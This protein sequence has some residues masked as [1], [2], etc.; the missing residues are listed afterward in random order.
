MPTKIIHISDIHVGKSD[1]EE[2]NFDKI[3]K[4]IVN[5][6][7]ESDK[8]VILITGDLVDDGKEKQ[9]VKAR[10]I[11]EPL[12]E[13]KFTL[14]PVPGNHDYG[15][16]G[17]H[18]R[19]KRFKYFKSAFYNLENVGYPHVK[20]ING[21]VFIGL[22]SMKA[23]VGFFDGLLADGELGPRQINDTLGALKKCE[24]RSPREKVI[25]HLHHHPFLFPDESPVKRLLEKAGHWLKDGDDFMHKISGRVDILIFGHDHEH[26]NFSRTQVSEKYRIP[27]ILSSGKSTEI[28][29]EY[30]VSNEGKADKS[31]VLAEGLLGRMIEINKDGT[32]NVATIK[33][34]DHEEIEVI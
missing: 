14:L 12:Y 11:L 9:F 26:R 32:I 17:N 34:N 5:K 29:K 20:P 7:W 28:G 4:C 10:E 6:D 22:N 18:A 23:E 30:A 31:N 19:E 21:H 16:N 8:P 27:I 24:D 13:R 3:V 33:F 15:W 1:D 25:M 2:K